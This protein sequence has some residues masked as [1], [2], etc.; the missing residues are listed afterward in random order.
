[1]SGVDAARLGDQIGHSSAFAGLLTGV[2]VALAVAVAVVAIVGTGGVAAVAIG[3]GIAAG[4]AGGGLSGAYIGEAIPGAPTG[5]LNSG[6][7]DVIIGG[8]LAARADLD[9]GSCSKHPNPVP[10]IAEG[11]DS[12]LINDLPAARKGDKLTCGAK[13]RKGEPTVL[14]GG[15][16]V[17][18]REIASEIPKWLT[19]TLWGIVIVGTTIATG[20]AAAVFGW[21]P[22]L[23]GF[24]G[25]LVGGSVLGWAGGKLGRTVGGWFGNGELG[26]RIG[27]TVGA[28]IGGLLGAK[29]GTRVGTPRHPD[30]IAV[31]QRENRVL[32]RRRGAQDMKK[33]G[34]T[35][36][37]IELMRTKRKPI[38]FKDEKQYQQ[39]RREL[40]EALQAEGLD[41]AGVRMRGTATTFYSENP[42][43]PLGHHWDADPA[44]PGDFDLE[45][46]SS[47]LTQH[48]QDAGYSS[49]PDIPSIYKTRHVMQEYPELK[50]FSS[51]WESELGREVNF[52]GLTDNKFT[53]TTPSDFVLTGGR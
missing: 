9:T 7:A 51:R 19:Y 15:N 31:R 53:S 29:V 1:M 14:I 36:R 34:V 32:F 40:H 23:G 3:A 41:D 17:Q 49:H 35:R 37:D 50:A 11:S 6:S 48:M 44:H 2:L 28:T 27:E 45:L 16:T 8:C 52:V 5:A 42:K 13:I 43:K 33:V 18:V 20:G 46:S 24:V 26:A 25:G 21:G 22:V 38:G 10:V 39:F 4:A 12:V 47:Q 30:K